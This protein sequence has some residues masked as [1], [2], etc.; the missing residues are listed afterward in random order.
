MKNIA[1]I[2]LCLFSMLF[3]VSCSEDESDDNGFSSAELVGT[4]DLVE[5]NVN[6]EVDLDGDGSFSSNLMDE[7]PCISGSIVL[8]DDSTYQ[9]EES[10]FTVTP[11]TNGLYFVQCSGSTQ[12][13]GAWASNGSEV[14]FHG[15]TVLNT[16][17][18]SNN[19]LIK[20]IGDDL[21][22][23]SSFVYERR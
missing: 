4:W 13:T 17:E 10:N 8:R 2:T 19:R 6:T 12:A 15:S 22:G 11:I 16:L 5:V 14:A 9:F 3:V 1:S 7:E 20:T 21:P 18:L 23:I